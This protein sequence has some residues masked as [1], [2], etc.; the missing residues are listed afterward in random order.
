MA[1][2]AQQPHK[3]LAP[4]SSLHTRVTRLLPHR[5]TQ[6]T[7]RD[8]LAALPEG[9]DELLG[10]GVLLRGVWVGSVCGL[11][12]RAWVHRACAG[13]RRSWRGVVDGAWREPCWCRPR[14]GIGFDPH[15]RLQKKQNARKSS[16]PSP[17]HYRATP[18]GPQHTTPRIR[19]RS[20][21]ST[22]CLH[23]P[24]DFHPSHSDIAC[25][26]SMPGPVTHRPHLRVL[27][28]AARLPLRRHHHHVDGRALGG[29]HLEAGRG[30]AL[31]GKGHRHA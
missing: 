27:L 22:P 23:A 29:N 2:Q 11:A 24:S 30:G 13:P 6:H 19:V 14:G 7:H 3:D 18:Y 25:P 20:A 28:P 4:S 1:S 31:R 16:S 17:T 10:D 21:G 26:T 9:A 5:H 15:V 8:Q 12:C